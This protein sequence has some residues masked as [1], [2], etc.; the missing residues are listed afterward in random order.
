MA[1]RPA[2]VDFLLV[3]EILPVLPFCPLSKISPTFEM[4]LLNFKIPDLTL[5]KKINHV[6][7]VESYRQLHQVQP[8]R[9]RRRQEGPQARAEGR[10]Q[11]R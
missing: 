9:C 8:G 7:L 1:V 3:T 4:F 2:V 11:G 6:R 5:R 10:S